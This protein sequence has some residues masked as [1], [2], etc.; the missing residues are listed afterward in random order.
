MTNADKIRSMTDE[1]LLD[2]MVSVLGHYHLMQI[3]HPSKDIFNIEWLKQEADIHL[4][5]LSTVF[6]W[7]LKKPQ[8]TGPMMR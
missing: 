1:Q 8:A 2:F 6:G 3:E 7:I 4:L 5:T